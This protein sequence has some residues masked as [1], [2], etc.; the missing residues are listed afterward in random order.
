MFYVLEEPSTENK[1]CGNKKLKKEN[2]TDSENK[3]IHFNIVNL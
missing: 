2:E 3:V 1:M